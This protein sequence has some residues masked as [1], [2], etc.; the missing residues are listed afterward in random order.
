MKVVEKINE[1]SKIVAAL[2][3]LT[4][5]IVSLVGWILILIKLLT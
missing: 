5:K 2:E 1:L 3:K 4:I